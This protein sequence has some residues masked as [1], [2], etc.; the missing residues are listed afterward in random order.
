MEDQNLNNLLGKFRKAQVLGN[1]L[2]TVLNHCGFMT[3]VVVCLSVLT[4]TS[5]SYTFKGVEV[6]TQLFTGALSLTTLVLMLGVFGEASKVYL[7]SN[8]VAVS[9]KLF[10]ASGLGPRHRFASRHF[11]SW[12]PI[13][14][15]FFSSNFFDR[16][17]VLNVEEFCIQNTINLLLLG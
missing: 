15:R 7:A 3:A 10:M 14:V 6:P 17:T 2:N 4:I 9:V 16:L 13:K 5:L 1:L 12:A 11:R 8:E